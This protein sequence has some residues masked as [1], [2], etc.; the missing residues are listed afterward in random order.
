MTFIAGP[1]DHTY[2][3]NDIGVTED[4]IELENVWFA[5]RIVGDNTGDSKVDGVQRG[6]DV[7]FNSILEEWNMTA[8]QAAF[9]TTF[10]ALGSMGQV[11][12]LHSNLASAWVAT[13]IA[14]TTAATSPASL[15]LTYSI[16]AENFPITRMFN[17][18]LRQVPIR[19]S[20]LPSGVDSAQAAW[21]ATT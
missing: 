7:F 11:G 6:G 8:V 18:R 5:D 9:W 17:A 14:G 19:M 1:Y 10:A 2:N 13:A 20:V 15:T 16:V 12:R 3:S 21:F 4:G